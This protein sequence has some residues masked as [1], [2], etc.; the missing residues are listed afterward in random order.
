VTSAPPRPTP[1]DPD[2]PVDPCGTADPGAVVQGGGYRITVLTSR[3][4]RVERDEEDRF[5]D[6]PTQVVLRRRLDVPRYRV[7]V[8]AGG[9]DLW[10]DHLHL[11]YD[12]GPLHAAGLSV[13]LLGQ[14]RTAHET[15]W[16][17]SDAVEVGPTGNLGGT[18]RTL[19]A[20]DGAAPLDPGLVSR[21][22]IAVI[23][24]SDSLLLTPDG[25]V[26]PRQTQGQDLYVLAYGTDHRAAVR[27]WF[28]VTG[29]SPLLPR[30]VL[31]NWWSRFHRYTDAEYLTLMDRFAEQGMPFSVAVVD[32]DWHLTDIDPTLGTGWTGYTWNRDLFPDPPAFLAELRRRGLR[33]TLNVHPADGVRRHEEAY[34]D[35]ARDLGLD[36]ADGLA[37]AFDIGSPTFVEAYLR[38]LHHPQEAAGVDFWWLDWQ[39]GTA[40]RRAGLDP[41]WMLNHVHYRDAGRD[42]RRPLTFS[43]Y[44]GLGSHR[45]PVGFSGDTIISWDSLAFQPSFTATAA[46]VGYFWWSHDIGGHFFGTKD[47]ELATRWVQLGALSPVNRLHSSNNPFTSKEPWRFGPRAEAIMRR[48]LRLRHQLVP[49]LYSAMWAAHTDGVGPVRPMYHDHPTQVPAYEVPHQYL[50]GADL[51]VVPVTSPMDRST[52]L[53]QTDAWLPEGRW[54]DLLTGR[55]YRGGRSLRLYRT[56]DQVPVLARAGAVLPLAVDPMADPGLDPAA[57]ALRLVPGADGGCVV[58]EDDGRGAVSVADRYETAV[59]VRWLDGGRTA[60]LRVH[61]PT[62]DGVLRRRDLTVE[63][64]GARLGRALLD[65]REVPVQHGVAVEIGPPLDRVALGEVDLTQGLELRLEEVVPHRSDQRAEVFALLDE[66]EIAF[67]TKDAAWSAAQRLDGLDLVAALHALDLPGNLLGGLL[68]VLGADAGP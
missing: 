2:D 26:A 52:H 31:G 5:T 4:I 68:E 8:G 18:T 12:E 61:P 16:R 6:A 49:Y 34:P 35:V 10:T 29:A 56:L 67:A 7:T 27:E 47:V 11:H 43:R 14:A 36:P 13:T 54:F 46:N 63:V 20:V 51:I 33:T 64:L 62:G 38:R 19:D 3:M 55:V 30:W 9:L 48:F 1:T 25:W 58:L 60:V 37:V 40:S 39:S 24:D 50:L 66:A 45:Y 65:G 28:T 21:T 17:Y 59:E 57:L 44:A 41:L 53:A 15:T 42:G 32:M 23:D 22:G